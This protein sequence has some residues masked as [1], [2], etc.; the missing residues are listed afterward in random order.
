LYIPP[1]FKIENRD[2]LIR[3]MRENMFAAL[4]SNGADGIIATHLPILVQ[5][6]P[7]SLK[8]I[9]HM[10]LAN[11][12]WKSFQDSREVLVIFQG[13]HAYISPSHY[14]AKPNVPTWNYAAVH[15]YGIPKAFPDD[16][17]KLGALATLFQH[18]EPSAQQQWDE[19]S[20]DYRARLLGGMIAFEIALTRLEGK[21]KLSQNR[22]EDEQEQ[23]AQSLSGEADSVR[24]GIGEMMKRNLKLDT[25]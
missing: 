24:A 15:A 17:T 3:F 9:G 25:D 5:D 19:A 14:N 12:Q 18:T 2:E 1:H 20:G 8:L 22:A 7:G 23:I 10:A 13:P 4:V 21:Y 16:P 6:D 11:P